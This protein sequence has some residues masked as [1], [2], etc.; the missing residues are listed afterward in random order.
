M[1][2]L[3]YPQRARFNRPKFIVLLFTP[4]PILNPLMD[5]YEVYQ[6]N[7]DIDKIP[8]QSLFNG[9]NPIISIFFQV[10][11]GYDRHKL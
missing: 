11:V 3:F 9:L 4:I 8:Q 10:M 2:T 7:V 6:L 5:S 1:K